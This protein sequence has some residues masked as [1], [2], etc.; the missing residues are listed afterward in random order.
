MNGEPECL[1]DLIRQ[2][3]SAKPF[4]PFEIVTVTGERCLIRV[5]EQ[6]IIASTRLFYVELGT[7][8]TKQF[9]KQDVVAVKRPR[10]C[11]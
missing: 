6:L 2:Y 4:M 8:R 9:L 7:D 1:D 3:K 11:I 10:P 5:P